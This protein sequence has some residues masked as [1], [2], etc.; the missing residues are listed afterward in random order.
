MHQVIFYPVQNGDTSQIILSNGKRLLF[1]FRHLNKGENEDEPV[2]DLKSRLRSELTEAKRDYYDVLALTHADLD[3]ISH[4]TEFFELLHANKYQGNGRI[5]VRELWVP[6]AMLLESS[7]IDQRSAEFVIWR[8]EAQH[9]LRK[10]KGIKIFSKPEML[11]NWLEKNYL[12]LESR[13]HLII[14]AGD[15]VPDFTL[16]NDGVEFFCH[17]PFIKHVKD[18]NDILRN[19]ASLIFQIRFEVG[20]TQTNYLAVGD[21]TCDVLEDIVKTSTSERH[22]NQDRLKWDLFNIPHHCS[23]HALNSDKG[24]YETV[25]LPLVKELLL[26]GQKNAYLISSSKPI[27]NDK[28]AYEQKQPPHIQ[29]RNCYE[30]YLKQVDGRRFIVTMEEPDCQKPQPLEFHITKAGVDLNPRGTSGVSIIVNSPA[31]RAG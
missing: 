27:K 9:R 23:H 30:N 18:S 2:I 5:K 13:R 24:K 3:H 25:P 22:N 10:G 11:K 26:Y 28:Q 31:P 6:A 29:A 17:S 4:S 15:L 12:T 16:A 1:D 8:R 20:G 19:D 14:N 21:S 7:T